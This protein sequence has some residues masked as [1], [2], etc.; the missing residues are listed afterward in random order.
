[1]VAANERHELVPPG[2]SRVRGRIVDAAMRQ[3]VPFCGLRLQHDG[4]VEELCSDAAGNFASQR[5]WP[6]TATITATEVV[7]SGASLQWPA[8]SLQSVLARAPT[9]PLALVDAADAVTMGVTLLDHGYT[10]QAL[11]AVPNATSAAT[12]PVVLDSS[13]VACVPGPT[14]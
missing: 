2:W 13:Q 12:E 8:V 9:V 4:A 11:P 7:P 3:P 10:V 1:V 5:A 6:Q 14:T